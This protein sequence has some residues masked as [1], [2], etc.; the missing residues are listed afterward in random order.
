MVDDGMVVPPN[1]KTIIICECSGTIIEHHTHTALDKTRS[2][3]F[4]FYA[5]EQTRLVLS[6]WV[7]LLEKLYFY[8]KIDSPCIQFALTRCSSHVSVCIEQKP[9]I[10]FTNKIII[11]A[12][13]AVIEWSFWRYVR[14]SDIRSVEGRESKSVMYFEERL[15]FTHATHQ[16]IQITVCCHLLP[17]NDTR[18]LM[19]VLRSSGRSIGRQ[20]F[21]K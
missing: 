12:I 17:S 3:R 1:R 11:K 14:L 20:Y 6:E 13:C 16:H 9:L 2:N 10:Y 8:L 21:A 7:F 5:S 19:Q 4:V 18:I 15:L